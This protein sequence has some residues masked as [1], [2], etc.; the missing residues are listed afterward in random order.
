MTDTTIKSDAGDLAQL[1]VVAGQAFNDLLARMTADLSEKTASEVVA[2]AAQGWRLGV[3]VTIDKLGHTRTCL[4]CVHK[5]EREEIAHI[6]FAPSG[7][8]N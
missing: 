2:R 1:S 3:E 6:A 4:V 5:R 7:A 8:A